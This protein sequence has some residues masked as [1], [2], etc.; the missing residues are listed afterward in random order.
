MYYG[1]CGTQ[2]TAFWG[3]ASGGWGLATSHTYAAPA[4]STF[5]L[6]DGALYL[7]TPTGV[8]LARI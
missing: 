4:S 6:S 8:M 5:T 2:G 7:V 1:T 3:S